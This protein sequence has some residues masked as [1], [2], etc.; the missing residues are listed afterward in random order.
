MLRGI[1][2]SE[3]GKASVF[4]PVYTSEKLFLAYVA[5]LRV[6]GVPERITKKNLGVASYGRQVSLYSALVSLGF[7]TEDGFP[8]PAIRQLVSRDDTERD[9]ALIEGLKRVYP[10][11]IGDA[12]AVDLSKVTNKEIAAEI[13]KAAGFSGSTLMKATSFFIMVA[14]GAGIKFRADVMK[15]HRTVLPPMDQIERAQV[16]QRDAAS[17][18][19]ELMASLPKFDPS[20]PDDRQ[21]AWFSLA[22]GN[23]RLALES[24]PKKPQAEGK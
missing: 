20:W 4:K 2:V 10:Y 11:L 23:Q 17:I 21:K 13:E 8:L 12:A 7:I 18:F 9:Y 24:L 14:Q 15:R 22:E 16:P 19:S 6:G 1:D 5:S 3:T